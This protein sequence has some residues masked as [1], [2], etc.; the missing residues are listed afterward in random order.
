MNTKCVCVNLV[1]ANSLGH[2][3]RTADEAVST[4]THYYGNKMNNATTIVF[5]S[6]RHTARYVQVHPVQ[7]PGKFFR[8]LQ[9]LADDTWSSTAPQ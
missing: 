4:M 7:G 3:P 9:F 5:N 6:D 2:S 1:K 8:G